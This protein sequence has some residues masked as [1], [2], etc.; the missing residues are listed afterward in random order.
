MWEQ[1]CRIFAV[2]AVGEKSYQTF[3]AE[4]QKV[5]ALGFADYTASDA[6]SHLSRFS[7]KAATDEASVYERAVIQ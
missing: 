2:G 7:P 1:C 6:A 3:C 5:P 4:G